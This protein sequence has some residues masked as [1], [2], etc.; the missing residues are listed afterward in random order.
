MFHNFYCQ[1]LDAAEKSALDDSSVDSIVDEDDT[2]I[3]P[4]PAAALGPYYKYIDPYILG[5]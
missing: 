5:F 3:N 2:G 1:E 4:F